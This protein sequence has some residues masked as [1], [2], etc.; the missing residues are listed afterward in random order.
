MINLTNLK[1]TMANGGGYLI[2]PKTGR[3]MFCMFPPR[4]ELGE[5]HLSHIFVNNYEDE[6][7]FIAHDHEAFVVS[8]VEG[9][10]II[11]R[12]L[13]TQRIQDVN[14]SLDSGRRS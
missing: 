6:I 12:F 14:E 8:G 11:H 3:N 4:R 2:R 13:R 1:I 5:L 9:T 7:T 10:D